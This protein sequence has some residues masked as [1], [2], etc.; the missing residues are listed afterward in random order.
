MATFQKGNKLGNRFSSTNQPKRKNGRKPKVYNQLK[1]LVGESVGFELEAE[2]Y[3]NIIRFLMECDLEKLEKL[4][5]TDTNKLNP[6][7]P[8]WVANIVTAMNSDVRY[9]RTDTLEM[10]LDRVFGKAVQ[11]VQGDIYTRQDAEE[12]TEEELEAEIAS[13]DEKLK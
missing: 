2:D 1:K 3:N 5:K 6:K 8:M 4:I 7:V 10:L 11:P 12:M 9:G 13:I